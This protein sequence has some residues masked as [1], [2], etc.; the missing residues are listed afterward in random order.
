MSETTEDDG[1]DC[2]AASHLLSAAQDAAL[3]PDDERRLVEHLGVCSMCRHVQGQL[4]VLRDA[5][6][7]LG[8]S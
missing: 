3:P 4:G 5:V 8:S 2:R 6:R 1:I 7:Q